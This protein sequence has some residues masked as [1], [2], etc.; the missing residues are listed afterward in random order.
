VGDGFATIGDHVAP[1]VA[2]GLEAVAR[3][4]KEH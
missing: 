1:L 3:H 2:M 4:E